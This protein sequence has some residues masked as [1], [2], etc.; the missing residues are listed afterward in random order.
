MLF[1]HMRS[2]RRLLPL[3]ALV[4]AVLPAAV[5][6][7]SM[8]TAGTLSMNA[9][10]A[11][12]SNLGACAQPV[13]TD[14]CAAR[15]IRGPFRGL[16]Q[17]DARYEFPVDSGG[18]TCAE[19]SGKALGYPIRL[20]VVGKGDIRLAVAEGPCRPVSETIYNQTQTFTVTGG[21]GSYVGSSGGGTLER[22]LGETTSSGRH[23]HEVWT[24]TLDVPGLEFD[25]T[26]PTLTG[27]TN[28]TVKAKKGAKSARLSF[29]VSAQDD[30]DG[31]RA[32][33]CSP[34]SGSAFRIGR[35]RVTCAASDTSANTAT[36]TF[37]ITVRKTR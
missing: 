9:V 29:R 20:T 32:V 30:R 5:T 18:P 35:T 28:K 19:G 25:L 22:Q 8:R 1:A 7:S 31:V 37:T 33:T 4:A 26:R 11:L 15:V 13:S 27:A 34:R 16:G 17:I 36:A 14:E 23:G 6:A 24:G 3:V 12:S 10:L 2:V 21:T